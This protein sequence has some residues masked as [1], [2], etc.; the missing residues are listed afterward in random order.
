L[1]DS[2]RFPSL[3]AES[4]QGKVKSDSLRTELMETGRAPGVSAL[5]GKEN[6]MLPL[7]IGMGVPVFAVIA[8]ALIQ[9]NPPAEAGRQ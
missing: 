9:S 1:A 5:C 6:V 2:H 4:S 3:A 7:M 8:Y